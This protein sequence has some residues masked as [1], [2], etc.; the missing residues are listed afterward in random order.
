MNMLCRICGKQ[1]DI[2]KYRQHVFLACGDCKP[3]PLTK[4]DKAVIEAAFESADENPCAD[5]SWDLIDGHC[6]IV[7]ECGD[8][9]APACYKLIKAIKNHDDYKGE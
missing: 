8:D 3:E 9:K 7:E 1:K 5:C 6:G 4:Q 2:D